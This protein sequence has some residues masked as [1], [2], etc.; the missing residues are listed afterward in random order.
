MVFRNTSGPKDVKWIKMKL[1]DKSDENGTPC[2]PV[3]SRC[4]CFFLPYFEVTFDVMC[5][6]KLFAE[7]HYDSDVL[8]EFQ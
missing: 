7:A 4:I 1:K 8:L 5:K 3:W 2:L 6:A